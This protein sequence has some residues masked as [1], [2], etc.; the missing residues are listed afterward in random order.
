M[1]KE[2]LHITGNGLPGSISLS[3]CNSFGS[4]GLQLKG[5][6]S[7][8][9]LCCHQHSHLHSSTTVFGEASPW[10][11]CRSGA[12]SLNVINGDSHLALLLLKHICYCAFLFESRNIALL[13]M[14][15]HIV[16]GCLAKLNQCLLNKN[17]TLEIRSKVLPYHNSS[18]N[19]YLFSHSINNYW[20]CTASWI[21]LKWENGENMVCLLEMEWY[22]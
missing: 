19:I 16:E 20:I 5:S 12:P 18:V 21:C 10:S 1:I 13:S 15:F 17:L 2:S 8:L 4:Q 7:Y 9:E 11:V 22:F 3:L 14:E 6:G